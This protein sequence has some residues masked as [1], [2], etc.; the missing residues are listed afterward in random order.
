MQTVSG[1]LQKGLAGGSQGEMSAKEKNGVLGVVQRA[2]GR[3][4]GR[5]GAGS[6]GGS[7]SMAEFL[8]GLEPMVS[9]EVLA[10]PFAESVWVQRAIKRVAGPIASVPLVLEPD[11]EELRAFWRAPARGM[12][13]EELV[14]ASVG[15]LK[16][17]GEFFWIM[18]DSW[19]VPGAVRGPLIVARPD[20]MR[21][22]TDGESLIGW[23]FTDGRG[24]THRLVPEQVVHV[25][26]WNPYSDF[27]GLS[28]M[29]AAR[30]AAETD[31]LQ[32]RF[33]RHLAAANGDTGPIIIAKGGLPT[34]EQREMIVREFRAKRLANQRGDFRPIFMAGE[35]QI[36]DSRIKAPDAAFVQ[37]RLGNRHEIFLAFGVPPSM[38]DIQASYSV[39]SASDRYLL[40]E[41]TCKPVAAKLARA[42]SEVSRRIV[43]AEVRAEFDWDEHSTMQM[44][45]RERIEV[46]MKLW[47]AGMPMQLINEYLEL[48][49]PEFE[50]WEVGYLPMGVVPA[51]EV[52]APETMP[53]LDENRPAAAGGAGSAGA[54]GLMVRALRERAEA[55]R[56][57]C[58]CTLE[59]MRAARPQWREQMVRR[60]AWKKKFLG[61][62]GRELMRARAE[63]LA[64]LERELGPEGRGPGAGAGAG[65]VR[66]VAAELMFDLK[67]FREGLVVGLKPLWQSCLGTAGR[68]GWEELQKDGGAFALP[69]EPV[70]EFLRG[71]ENRISGAAQ[72]I[73]EQIKAQ[74]EAGLEAGETLSELSD[75]VR[76]AFNEVGR[77]RAEVIAI[78]ETNVCFGQGRELGMKQA[79]VK[80]KKWLTSGASNVRPSHRELDGM[81]V[82]MDE[83][84]PNGCRFPGDPDGP[85]AEVIN[86]HCTH[87]AASEE[88]AG[89]EEEEEA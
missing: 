60:R 10:R 56:C 76:A 89:G 81:V 24:W 86:C 19:L 12:G 11:S 59:A 62:I 35:I 2:W 32:S 34:Q 69:P 17:T 5:S 9:G 66:A 7:G 61:R 82:G 77:G 64:K 39:G 1:V 83:V 16:L 52:A 67:N 54:A 15:W 65:A 58:G 75:R 46:G 50:G 21:E 27:R 28:E 42:I 44:V 51:S 45:R 63:V 47:S 37:Q 57:D 4:T 87:V 13:F 6:G 33:A 79:G 74:L 73:F 71:R 48:G 31:W 23:V 29:G 22:V 18:D 3:L 14:E 68:E 78:T 38:A 30:L 53:E 49:L 84:F 36:E 72:N 8:M 70:L 26:E 43:G 88:G 80:W 25:R 40:I 41:E 55:R 20:R 85:A